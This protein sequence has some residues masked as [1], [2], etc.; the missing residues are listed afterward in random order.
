[1][2]KPTMKR[3]V[4]EK[5]RVQCLNEYFKCL[6]DKLP[7]EWQTKKMSKEEILRKSSLYIRHLRQFLTIADS[8][9][10]NSNETFTYSHECSEIQIATRKVTGKDTICYHQ[11]N[12]PENDLSDKCIKCT[13][14][15]QCYS[16]M[17][18][19]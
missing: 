16:S 10:E 14:E 11:Q 5:R 12:C 2:T 13:G 1:M 15:K 18:R 3:N 4:R 9:D 17:Y 8:F 7:T 6:R 19:S